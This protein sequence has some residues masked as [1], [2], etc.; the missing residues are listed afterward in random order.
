MRNSW[1]NLR[2]FYGTWRWQLFLL[3]ECEL[4]LS[5]LN[6]SC[7]FEVS[8]DTIDV[9]FNWVL[10]RFIYFSTFK[11]WCMCWRGLAWWEQRHD[12][13]NQIYVARDD[14]IKIDTCLQ[15][16]GF[17]PNTSKCVIC[18]EVARVL[19]VSFKVAFVSSS[20]GSKDVHAL[21]ML[22]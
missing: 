8:L 9:E 15:S 7:I 12:F 2:S 5:L 13:V 11:H 20:R 16:V 14:C 3:D 21:K 17:E 19:I 22:E 1:V 4:L 10:L 18:Y 6:K